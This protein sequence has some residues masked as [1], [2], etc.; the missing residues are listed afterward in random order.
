MHRFFLS[1]SRMMAFLGGL[2]LTAVV[3]I[4]CLSIIGREMNSFLNGDLM[5]AA[6]PGL[7]NWLLSLG[8]GPVTGDFELVEAGVAFAIFAFLPLCQITGG[9][10]TVD[11]FT[12]RFPDRVNRALRAVIEVVFAAVL[13]LIAVQLFDGMMGKLRT[14]QTTFLLQFPVWWGYAAGLAGAVVAAAV[15]AYLALM[16]VA[17]SVTGTRILPDEAEAVH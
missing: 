15:A 9:H 17:E 6:L 3:I 13:I 8:I 5:Q 14:G 1:L 4:V 11:I 10:A 7:A 16:R 12:S 2:V